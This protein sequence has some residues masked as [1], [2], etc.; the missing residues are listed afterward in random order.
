MMG[1]SCSRKGIKYIHYDT[2]AV[3]EV[4]GPDGSHAASQLPQ[5]HPPPPQGQIREV[6]AHLWRHA[7]LQHMTPSI[8]EIR[9]YNII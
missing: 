9:S 8:E 4:T 3:G 6:G 1:E 2:G 7:E 5:G